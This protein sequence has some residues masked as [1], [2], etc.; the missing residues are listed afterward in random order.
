MATIKAA[1]A[2]ASNDTAVWVGGVVPADGDSIDLDGYVVTQAT[3]AFPSTGAIALLGS[4][5]KVGQWVI[6]VDTLGATQVLN[7]ATITPGTLT[8]VGFVEI[9]GDTTG[10]ALSIANGSSAT[11][12]S[13]PSAAQ[14]K[15][16]RNSG[17]G[18]GVVTIKATGTGGI[19]VNRLCVEN[20]STGIMTLNGCSLTGGA[21]GTTGSAGGQNTSTGTVNLVD[22]TITGG[23]ASLNPGFNNASTGT[24]TFNNV[25]QVNTAGCMA[26]HGKSPT[27]VITNKANYIQ[28][29][30]V[31][32]DTRGSQAM[33]FYL[34]PEV[35]EVVDGTLGGFE[36]GANPPSYAAAGTRVDCP[37]GK[38]VTS[39]GN[40]GD[41]ASPLVGTI[42]SSIVDVD[43][44]VTAAPGIIDYA[45][46]YF[47]LGILAADGV[48]CEYGTLDNAGAYNVIGIIESG[49]VWHEE[50]VLE[51]LGANY[52]TIA[53][54]L[55]TPYA[56]GEAAGGGFSLIGDGGM[57]G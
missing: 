2:G 6:P 34:A 13:T 25:N 5:A 33:R 19:S 7:V 8:L 51:T 23:G 26:Y 31:N 44:V 38:A 32:A 47:A 29:A 11:V 21:S 43:G 28:Y 41:P 1:K 46:T 9:T 30:A 54:T 53:S 18:T 16:I 49:G 57:I 48:Y 3:D 50:G 40:Y 52:Y 27:M 17:T 42:E 15:V 45:G 12:L 36:D 4:P 35:G 37:V 39:S 20:A 55:S 24:V 22:T 14:Q 56:N 10:K